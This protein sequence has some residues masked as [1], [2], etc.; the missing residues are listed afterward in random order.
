MVENLVRRQPGRWP[1]AVALAGALAAAFLVTGCALDGP[2][3]TLSPDGPVS[4]LQFDIFQVTLWVSLSIFLVVGSLT[5]YTVFRFRET[6]ESAAA[7][8]PP[9][10]HG[11]V[12]LE[13]SLT[14][15]SILLV[16]IIAFP[17]VQGI[18]GMATVP[19]NQALPPLEINVTAY[20][21]W[22]SF[23]YPKQPGFDKPLVIANEIAIPTNRPVKFNLRTNDIIHSFWVPR[24]A[25]KMDVIPNQ[26][27]WLWMQADKP[28][29]YFGQCAEFCGESHA[30]MKFRVFAMPPAEFDGWI[31]HQQSDQPMQ[32][33]SQD[34]LAVQGQRVFN[35]TGKCATCH[36]VRGTRASYGKAGPD[37]T[38]FGSRDMLA[39]AWL[40]NT[41]ANVR[42]WLA[43]NWKIKPGNYM[44]RGGIALAD[45]ETLA[46]WEHEQAEQEHW[47]SAGLPAEVV[48]QAVKTNPGMV[49]LSP[50][51]PIPKPTLTEADIDALVAYLRTLR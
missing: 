21:W 27:N 31:A 24:L 10:S 15:I 46:H 12:A 41:D 50:Y 48:S 34:P 28:G 20:Q 35:T 19:T 16:G 8:L 9:Q 7:G 33:A 2:Q 39:A 44:F 32:V 49:G 5:L 22:W 13:V 14:L 18:F 38:H 6:E 3:S 51:A 11:N 17:T 4:D 47:N 43:H 40:D 25:G 1:R 36:T 26:N 30:F 23:E 45:P 29:R 37:L 42:E